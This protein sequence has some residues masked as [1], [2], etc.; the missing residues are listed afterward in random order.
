MDAPRWKSKNSVSILLHKKLVAANKKENIF[1]G[2]FS[3]G[4]V[5]EVR[6]RKGNYNAVCYWTQV[7]LLYIASD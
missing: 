2:H 5:K 7:G 4:R 3:R 1:F 6:D